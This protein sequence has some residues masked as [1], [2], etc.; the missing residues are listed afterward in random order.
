MSTPPPLPKH[1]ALEAE[2]L[3]L[4]TEKRQLEELNVA[5]RYQLDQQMKRQG[6]IKRLIAKQRS[7]WGDDVPNAKTIFTL[8]EKELNQLIEARPRLIRGSR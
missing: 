2:V 4:R 1:R 7:Y 8:L 6:Q 3:G 5:L